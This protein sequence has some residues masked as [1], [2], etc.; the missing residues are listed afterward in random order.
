MHSFGLLLRWDFRP[1]GPILIL[2][3]PLQPGLLVKLEGQSWTPARLCPWPAGRPGE[4]SRPRLLPALEQEGSD[5]SLSGCGQDSET[6][7]R[8]RGAQLCW[9]LRSPFTVDL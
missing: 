9:E 1:P 4:L 5:A 8:G 2:H 6:R 3:C 7:S